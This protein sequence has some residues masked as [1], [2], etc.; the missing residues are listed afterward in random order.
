MAEKI[1]LRDGT[2]V[3][4]SRLD[5][6]QQFDPRSRD[7]P[8]AA[9]LG[10]DLKT[11]TWRLNE[12]N[13]QGPDGACVGFGV[14]HRLAAAPLELSK[15]NYDFSFA[16]YREAQK[17]DPWPGED[18]SGT[19]VLAG[20]Q[21][22]QARGHIGAYQWCFSVDDIARTVS[23]VGPVV[24]GTWWDHSMFQPDARGLL[25]PD[26][27]HAGG[28]CYLIR[29]VTL[30][31]T[32]KRKGLGPL[33]RITNSWGKNWG[34]NGDAWI[35]VED[36]ER[37]LLP[38]GDAVVPVERRVGYNRAAGLLWRGTHRAGAFNTRGIRWWD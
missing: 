32:G 31:P 21:A 35:T 10:S 5:R 24:V 26:G 4:D 13:D 8:V 15:V 6:L 22:A 2:Q 27:K 7:F 33:L 1:T 19:S 14:G 3:A 18:Y 17:I 12:R 16:L 38:E 29:G 9:V 25:V 28:H 20:I 11:K 30:K 23:Q 37:F 36:Y 34:D